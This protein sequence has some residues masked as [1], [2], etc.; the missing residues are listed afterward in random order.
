VEA[1]LPEVREAHGNTTPADTARPAAPLPPPAHA[2]RPKL[3][4]LAALGVT[5]RMEHLRARLGRDAALRA[6][7]LG[8]RIDV[9]PT[10]FA[11]APR[12]LS[13]TTPDR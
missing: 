4:D 1:D 12:R 6:D 9:P 8:R 10:N 5:W 2:V 11:R 7:S 3:P 13:G